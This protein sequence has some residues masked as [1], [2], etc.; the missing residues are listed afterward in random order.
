MQIVIQQLIHDLTTISQRY[1]A[2]RAG[3]QYD[4]YNEVQPFVQQVD[5]HLQSLERYQHTISKQK[6]FNI[7]KLHRMSSLM[8][9]LVVACHQSTTSKK[10][11]I[12]QYK[13]VQHDLNYLSQL[14][15]DTH[16]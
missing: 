4:F 11:F 14:E 3:R 10:L 6:Y 1:E 12:D 13:A 2:A 5:A 16:V 9:E 7:N 8:A 15:C